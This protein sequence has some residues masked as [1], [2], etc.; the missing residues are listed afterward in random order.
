MPRILRHPWL[1]A[2]MMPSILALASLGLTMLGG[3]SSSTPATNIQPPPPAE[4]IPAPAPENVLK[5]GSPPP[6]VKKS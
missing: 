6:R 2:L 1:G 3:C 5:S 4:T